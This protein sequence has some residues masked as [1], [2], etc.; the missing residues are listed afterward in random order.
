MR[1]QKLFLSIILTFLL[2]LS[3]VQSATAANVAM[4]VA[5]SLSLDVTHEKK[6][7]NLLNQSGH[8]ITLVDKNSN[9]DYNS[10]DLIVVAG[11]PRTGIMLDSFVANIPVN[12]VPTIAI[13][14]GYPDDWGWVRPAGLSLLTSSRMQD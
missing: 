13:D 5:N 2:T 1:N 11:R 4:V 6:I 7:F 9:V 14:Q 12:K 8:S 10:F 3:V